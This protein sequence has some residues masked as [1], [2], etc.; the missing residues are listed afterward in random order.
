MEQNIQYYPKLKAFLWTLESRDIKPK[1]YNI[2]SHEELEKQI[3]L[4]N[5]ILKL[6]YWY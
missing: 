5:S 4:V 2:S 3:K 1:E 6:A